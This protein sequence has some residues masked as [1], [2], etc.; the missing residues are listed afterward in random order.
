MLIA[1]YLSQSDA[2]CRKE[3]CL[4][5]GASL[6]ILLGAPGEALSVGRRSISTSR[7]RRGRSDHCQHGN[8][9]HQEEEEVL[10]D[11][12][13]ERGLFWFKRVVGVGSG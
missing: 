4:P 3:W 12:R 5:D 6:L 8:D 2:L 1:C 10:H 9:G 13:L 7:K 11:G